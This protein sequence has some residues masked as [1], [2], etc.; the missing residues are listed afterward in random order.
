MSPLKSRPSKSGFVAVAALSIAAA[1]AVGALG[2]GAA[3]AYNK[4][5]N[6]PVVES[7]LK[8]VK[9][10]SQ[11]QPERITEYSFRG[12]IVYLAEMPCCDHFNPLFSESGE[13]LCSPSGGFAG[14]G[15][16]KCPEFAAEKT[17]E[18]VIWE[19]KDN[20]ANLKKVKK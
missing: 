2:V 16:G 9:T 14:V 5:G 18:K 10:N 17:N 11:V 8:T 19:N 3:M 1:I 7:I 6:S 20:A 15:D 12:K 13:P 4:K